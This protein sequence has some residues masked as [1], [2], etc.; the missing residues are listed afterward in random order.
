MADTDATGA[1]R[2]GI[3]IKSIVREVVSGCAEAGNFVDEMLA[4]FMVKAVV[5]DPTTEFKSESELTQD[6]I[7]GLVEECIRRLQDERNV[8][9]LTYKLQVSFERG[10]VSLERMAERMMERTSQA[11]DDVDRSIVSEEARTHVEFEDVYRQMVTSVLLRSEMGPSDDYDVIRECTAA[12][13]SV[14]P[15]TELGVFMALPM[16]EK[17]E[18]LLYLC[19][20]VGGIRLFNKAGGKGGRKIPDP[21]TEVPAMAARVLAECHDDAVHFAEVALVYSTAEADSQIAETK[22]RYFAMGACAQQYVTYAALLHKDAAAVAT[23]A[24]EQCHRMFELITTLTTVVSSHTAVPTAEVYPHFIALA[25]AYDKLR[26]LRASLETIAALRLQHAEVGKAFTALMAPDAETLAKAR[27]DPRKEAQSGF[28]LFFTTL[29]TLTAKSLDALQAVHP[30][31]AEV[32]V[33]TPTEEQ[34]SDGSAPAKVLDPVDDGLKLGG[35]A[36]GPADLL[37][38][39]KAH[40]YD[41][42]ALNLGGFCAASA[43]LDPPL[44]L[45]ADHRLGKLKYDGRFYGFANRTGAASFDAD[46]DNLL[47]AVR[48]S[49]KRY[50]ELI[51]LLQLHEYFASIALD[52][53]TGLSASKK[54]AAPL[55]CDGGCQT[56]TH[57][58]E[59]NIV[60]GYESSE[61]ELRRRAIKLANLRTKKTRSVQTDRSNF[62]RSTEIQVYAP[63]ESSTQTRKDAGTGVPK[64]TTYIRGLR[65]P[66][67]RHAEPVE[68]VDLTLGIGGVALDISG[69]RGT[70][71]SA[72]AGS[73][74]GKQ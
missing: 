13:E 7:G 19:G 23:R 2:L 34:A 29:Y 53:T 10:Y 35:G 44:L 61:W 46:A 28:H 63:K 47:E 31:V 38:P 9:L 20:I 42:I 30:A 1:G 26:L 51:E 49:A 32:A 40:G 71:A 5:L 37:V 8:H 66:R 21:S 55:K 27:A 58:M 33:V 15:L 60:P 4:A 14:L 3:V 36:A 69:L 54:T 65:G 39:G 12:M 16:K 25:E 48:V 52:S 6:V 73:G 50:P 68:V 41:S 45:P 57:P 70:A 18:Q 43:A 56:E 24:A 72:T 11:V 59:S 62:R 67:G 64:P 17:R 22:E 74:T